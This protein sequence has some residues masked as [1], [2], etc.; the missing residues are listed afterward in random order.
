M[1][2]RKEIGRLQK[3]GGNGDGILIC[4]GVDESNLLKYFFI[5]ICFKGES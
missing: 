2:F 3:V 4:F 5:P 1:D